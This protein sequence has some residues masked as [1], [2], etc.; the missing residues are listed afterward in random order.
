[1]TSRA[2]L[3]KTADELRRT[4]IAGHA[5][6]AL[7]ESRV[8]DIHVVGRGRPAQARFSGKELR[9]FLDLDVCDPSID[10]RDI[11]M[12]D[13]AP[14]NPSDTELSE[15]LSLLRAFSQSHPAKP[16]RCIF[17]FGLSPVVIKGQTGVEGIA[18]A[19]QASGAVED[20]DC[21]L[22]FRSVGR[23]TA[24][25]VGVPYDDRRG[26]HANIEGRVVLDSAVIPGLY[27]CGWSKRGPTGTI[28]TNRACGLA[29][30]QTVLAD[31]DRGSAAARP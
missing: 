25:L 17:R 31:P 11:T 10:G 5:L 20:I 27:T 24:P 26:V 6:E 22:V 21:G 30:A 18:F 29:T 8:R 2:C 23:R 19:Q 7:S 15:K 9:E 28:G 13:F 3:A 12:G 4:D 14:D 16:R 1:M